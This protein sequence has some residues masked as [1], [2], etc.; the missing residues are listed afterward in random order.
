MI[1][2]K[3]RKKC[4]IYWFVCW[5]QSQ[6]IAITIPDSMIG[7]YFFNPV[8]DLKKMETFLLR[9]HI[10]SPYFGHPRVKSRVPIVAAPSSKTH[11]TNLR[12]LKIYSFQS[13]LTW[14]WRPLAPFKDAGPPESPWHASTPTMGQTALRLVLSLV[15]NKW[16]LWWANYFYVQPFAI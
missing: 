6:L 10:M 16:Q 9:A 14:K 1:E 5:L 8:H 2:L 3:K 7:C 12:D 15:P 11:D 4:Q 13:F